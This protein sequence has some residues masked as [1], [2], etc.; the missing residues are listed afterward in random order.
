M[1]R[2]KVIGIELIMALLIVTSTFSVC[3]LAVP[4]PI[5]NVTK[6]V[7]D[8]T[9]Q[10]WKPTITAHV[11]ETVHFNITTTYLGVNEFNNLYNFHAKDILP[12]NLHFIPG[13]ARF[14]NYVN[15]VPTQ[16]IIGNTIFWNFTNKGLVL[17]TTHKKMYI[18]FNANINYSEID[19]INNAQIKAAESSQ[20]NVSQNASATIIVPAIPVQKQVWNGNTWVE[21]INATRNNTVKFKI[22][23][24]F[25]S[26]VF[27]TFCCITR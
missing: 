25:V 1:R 4:D 18:E 14:I 15:A 27:N 16:T 12:A 13:S 6:T 7:W 26:A 21:S 10:S 23:I 2:N 3:V 9:S 20:G 22:T 8:P 24:A 17:D 5:L 11:G 19:T